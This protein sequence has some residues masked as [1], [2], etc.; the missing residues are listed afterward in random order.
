MSRK[1]I[2]A[3]LLSITI[4]VIV[5]CGVT[6]GGG[7][8]SSSNPAL[9]VK[10]L[11]NAIQ[12]AQVNPS[13]TIVGLNTTRVADSGYKYEGGFIQDRNVKLSPYVMA[14][15][16][17][18][19][20]QWREVYD[21]AV[22]DNYYTFANAG[23]QGFGTSATENHPVTCVTWRDCI[24]WCNA[25]TEMAYGND[26]QCVYLDSSDN[27][28]RDA[29]QW[30]ETQ[31]STVNMVGKK[32]YRLPTEAEWE[33]AARWQGADSTNALDYGGFYLTAPDSLSGATQ[34]YFWNNP[35]N[36]V[37]WSSDNSGLET[38][39]VGQKQ[40]N[41]LGLYDMAGNV[42]E[43][44]FDESEKNSDP[45]GNYTN[46]IVHHHGYRAWHITRG[47]SYH[48]QPKNCVVSYSCSCVPSN[49]APWDSSK[50]L[51]GFRVAY[52]R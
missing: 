44:C 4:L 50:D 10:Q 49:D 1:Q 15:H 33:Y 16:E 13:G 45:T 19:Y 52:S 51:V 2:L 47:G 11:S 31:V 43:W 25:Y 18:T 8:G 17:I 46:P 14:K 40:A 24:V 39:A 5:G 41:A 28:L 32:G 29:T 48:T 9:A 20:A 12:W 26:S 36:T 21:W 23:Q 30:V 34:N 7:G 6:S 27:V 38:H 35:N 42:W 37:G 3:F 22:S